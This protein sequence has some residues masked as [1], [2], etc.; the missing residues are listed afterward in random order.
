MIYAVHKLCLCLINC[1][2]LFDSEVDVEAFGAFL[3]C[4]RSSLTKMR[5]KFI[6]HCNQMSGRK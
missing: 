3:K 6:D 1:R 2:L 4:M 5:V